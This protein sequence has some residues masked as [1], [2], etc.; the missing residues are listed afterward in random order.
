MQPLPR[1]FALLGSAILADVALAHA[2][3]AAPQQPPAPLAPP[4]TNPSYGRSEAA[5]LTGHD[6]PD[7]VALASG[8]QP[9]QL[10]QT[11]ALFAAPAVH[12][13]ATLFA[14]FA[15]HAVRDFAV[16][17]GGDPAQRRDALVV[18]TDQG[19][20]CWRNHQ[21]LT[22]LGGAAWANA[23]R[24]RLGDLD[25]DGQ[26]EVVA[27]A[28]GGLQLLVQ[29]LGAAGA[30]ATWALPGPAQ[31]LLVTDWMPSVG[32]PRAELQV[33]LGDRLLV[34]ANG[35]SV[36]LAVPLPAHSESHLACFADSPTSR[37]L[38]LAYRVA[39]GTFALATTDPSF[40]L[41]TVCLLDHELVALTVA[42]GQGGATD[43]LV[44][45]WR[46]PLV[47][48]LLRWA[49][50]TA[51]FAGF[52]AGSALPFAW[53]AAQAAACAHLV[54][55]DGDGD[56]DALGIDAQ[57]GLLVVRSTQSDDR[58][59]V[60]GTGTPQ[61]HTL[62][63]VGAPAWANRVEVLYFQMHRVE[64]SFGELVALTLDGACQQRELVV[65]GGHLTMPE[66]SV[67]LTKGPVVTLVRHVQVQ[68]GAVVRRGGLHPVV[69]SPRLEELEWV[70]NAVP[71]GSSWQG[72]LGV[73]PAQV[74]P[75]VTPPNQGGDEAPE[76]AG[77]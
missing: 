76:G 48:S 27:L 34:W 24:V 56:L 30:P 68:G 59:A 58:V 14:E 33:A 43:G 51:G 44:A 57:A 11:L 1:F 74:E 19:L 10:C 39:G 38:A 75:P 66:T 60:Q 55:L 77:G 45:S 28:A 5:H 70:M 32:T 54:D 22:V 42:V 35:A 4:L 50:A 31:D 36:P 8:G 7:L 23:Q 37:R 3:H 69:W 17:T 29:T 9:G 67:S 12:Q 47:P 73:P 49:P 72:A 52:A 40:A 13:S 61:Q 2:N 16:W 62:A 25:G 63:A 64:D 6:V 26:P 53:T 65:L 20:F 71:G 46:D 18:V 21:P 15:G 41:P